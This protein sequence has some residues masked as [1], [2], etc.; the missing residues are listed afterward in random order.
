MG[1]RILEGEYDGHTAAAVM[2]CSTTDT[3]FGP[4]FEDAEQVESFLRF[5]EAQGTSDPRKLTPA[6][7]EDAHDRWIKDGWREPDE[8]DEEECDH[9]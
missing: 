8:Q 4:L 6:Q 9:A 3:A 1:V 7:L 2:I 5:L